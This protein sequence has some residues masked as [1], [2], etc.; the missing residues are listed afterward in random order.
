M[1][2][3]CLQLNLGVRPRN[4]LANF[5][6]GAPM[7]KLAALLSLVGSLAAA[8]V[9]SKASAQQPR[10]GTAL[11]VTLPN[12]RV[13]VLRSRIN[14][15][16]YLIQVALPGSYVNAKPGD[17]TRFRVLYI[18][19]GVWVFPFFYSSG[20]SLV[21]STN[22]ILVGIAAADSH[23][24]RRSY[25]YTPPLTS[26]DSAWVD[27]AWGGFRGAPQGGARQFLRVLSKEII[28]F[29]D[30]S[31]RTSG[32][33]GIEGMSL[34]G[35]FVAYAMLEE[36]DLFRRYALISPSLWYP[37]APRDKKL[38]L[39]S[40]REFAKRHPTF[41]KT[42]FISVGSEEDPGMISV[43]QQFLSE[44]CSSLSDGNLKGLDLATEIVEGEGHASV[45]ARLHVP[46]TLYPA[47][48]ALIKP[49]RPRM[50]ECP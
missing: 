24:T 3:L 44:L 26:A 5:A 8:A 25:D 50:R 16:G 21:E 38:I 43:A 4:K 18:L 32:D 10:T 14:G 19:D 2:V 7:C 31:Y 13:H 41:P 33:R 15:Q 12:T 9:F 29:I 40:Q 39:D 34:G 22:L 23:S 28:P 27:S 30:S 37:F 17:T 35:L 49:R 45:A 46:R 36:P 20:S 47:A 48:T 11:A 1:V 6:T 42:V